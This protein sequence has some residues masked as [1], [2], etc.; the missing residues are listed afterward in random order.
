MTVQRKGKTM[1]HPPF[2]R[3]LNVSMG[4]DAELTYIGKFKQNKYER[5]FCPYC[6]TPI[7]AET[8]ATDF[9]DKKSGRIIQGFQPRFEHMDLSAGEARLCPKNQHNHGKLTMAYGVLKRLA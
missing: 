7:R 2:R 3:I 5:L 6:R 8:K 4:R 1:F 9:K